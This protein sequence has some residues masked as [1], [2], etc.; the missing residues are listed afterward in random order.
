[1]PVAARMQCMAIRGCRWAAA[2]LFV[3]IVAGPAAAQEREP[4]LGPDIPP[5]PPPLTILV[6]GDSIAHD[7]GIGLTQALASYPQVTVVNEGRAISGLVRED[8]LNWQ[9]ELPAL[10]DRQPVDAVVVS[11][12][13]NDRQAITEGGQIYD[14]FTDAWAALY[15]ERAR[16]LMAAATSRGIPTVWLGMPTARNHTFHTDMAAIN[17]IVQRAVAADPEV[18]YLSMWDLT[19]DANGNYVE[20]GRA[21]DGMHLSVSGVSMVVAAIR[22]E[23]SR[24]LGVALID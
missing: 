8:F 23:L 4:G 17:E 3:L 7:L 13:M 18:S 24:R 11:I 14:R 2:W 16:A 21:N 10:L 1:M 5:P 20:H 6:V 9:T 19:A 22:R 15:E 12:G